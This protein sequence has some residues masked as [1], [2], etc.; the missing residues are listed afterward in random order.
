METKG[1]LH[2]VGVI[3]KCWDTRHLWG[4]GSFQFSKNI[5][6]LRELPS[7]PLSHSYG[8]LPFPIF[9]PEQIEFAFMTPQVHNVLYI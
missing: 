7:T 2:V 6:E 1:L 8:K 4:E 9:I 3:G 5:W